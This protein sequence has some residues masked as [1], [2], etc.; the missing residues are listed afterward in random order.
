MSPTHHE[1]PWRTARVRAAGPPPA[2]TAEVPCRVVSSPYPDDVLAARQAR[3]DA[4]PPEVTADRGLLAEHRVTG[5]AGQIVA[6][7]AASVTLR[8]MR[9][10]QRH[11]RLSPGAF[12][13]GGRT[14]TL[15]RPRPTR[16]G[17]QRTFTASG[18]VAS[19][20][21]QP[22][23]ARASR[24]Y[25]EGIHDAELLEKVWGDDLRDAGVVVEP[26]GGIDDLAAAVRAFGPGPQRRLGVLVDHLVPGSKE[27]RIVD[28][29][30]HPQVLITGH[31]YVDVWQGVRPRLLGI[32]A[33]PVVP[34]GQPWKEGICAAL[35]VDEP[36]AFWR[37]LLRS[38]SSYADLEQPLIGAVEQ[39]LD[40]VV[41][42]EQ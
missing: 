31:P 15:V 39:L 10:K 42:P 14:V 7:D 24:I 6:V 33:W 8:D 20:R 16:A 17:P 12:R 37:R 32:D 22:R 11:F 27:Q 40:F 35:G 25:V 2:D 34:H 38:V 41:P 3:R 9:G 19:T 30:S 29:V 5:F 36:P 4:T 13:V 18:S 1:C 23:V 28:T 21:T 26:L